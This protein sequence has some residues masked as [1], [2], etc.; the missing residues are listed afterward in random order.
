MK[1]VGEKILGAMGK[2]VVGFA[3]DDTSVK[4]VGKV[5]VKGDL[6]ETYDNADARE[7]LNF[8]GQMDSTVANFLRKRFIPRWSTADDRSYPGMAQFEAIVTCNSPRFT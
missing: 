1:T 4:Q 8:I 5:A 6:P 3:G 2:A 7:R